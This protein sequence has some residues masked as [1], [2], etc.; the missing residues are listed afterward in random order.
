M[1]WN[2]RVGVEN[3]FVSQS[4]F[5]FM[6][7][8]YYNYIHHKTLY[9]CIWSIQEKKI[10]KKDQLQSR[11]KFWNGELQIQLDIGLYMY[12]INFCHPKYALVFFIEIYNFTKLFKNFINIHEFFQKQVL[13]HHSYLPYQYEVKIKKST[14]CSI[15]RFWSQLAEYEVLFAQT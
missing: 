12:R 14:F 2:D 10:F 7:I 9:L 8:Y 13:C 3:L 4:I 1:K 15:V 5:V 6:L 11:P